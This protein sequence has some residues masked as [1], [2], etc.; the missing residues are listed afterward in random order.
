MGAR[1]TWLDT[2]KIVLKELAKIADYNVEGERR[3]RQLRADAGRGL[4]PASPA[5][6]PALFSSKRSPSGVISNSRR[7]R[8]AGA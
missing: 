1:R 5:A 6:P 8:T 4:M 7:S 3:F 2:V